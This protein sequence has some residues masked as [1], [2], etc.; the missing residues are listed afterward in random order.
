MELPAP[1]VPRPGYGSSPVTGVVV[2]LPEPMA[3]KG[4]PAAVAALAGVGG[5]RRWPLSVGEGESQEH[6]GA[7]G[8]PGVRLG[9][10]PSLLR[11]QPATWLPHSPLCLDHARA[12]ER[13][14]GE[15]LPYLQLVVER[16]CSSH[17]I[18]Y[19]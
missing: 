7:Y 14:I 17:K 3:G 13:E 12:R 4:Q 6:L 1:V 5:C 8:P 18:K 9:Q 10:A 16:C 11:P 15:R 19:N 2:V